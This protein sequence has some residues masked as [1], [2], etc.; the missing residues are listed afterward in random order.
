MTFAERT[1]DSVDLTV[2]GMTCS[3][4][5]A[6]I[7]STLNGLGGVEASVNFATDK[8]RVRY[9][10]D[11]HA[12]D[13][14]VAVVCELGYGAHVRDA[15]GVS[16]DAGH[17]HDHTEPLETA[18]RRLAVTA[19]FAVPVLA[20]SMIPALQIDRWQWIAFALSLPVVTWGAAPFHRTAFRQ[21]RH[22]ST[23][24]DTLI[25][26]GVLAAFGW[27]VYALV[28][29]GAGE[30]GMEMQVSL[31]RE[32]GRARSSTSRSPRV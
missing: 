31:T 25:S 7:E 24:M 20:L 27:S 18:G 5:A 17:E 26:L 30:V 4:C 22:R 9:D 16:H 1:T 29:G 32:A 21:L 23:T 15:A 6:K 12:P 10:A 28:W 14:L 11:R 19:L 2:T 13:D 3:A 8:A